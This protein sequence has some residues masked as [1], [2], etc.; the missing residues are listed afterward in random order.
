MIDNVI[1]MFTWARKIAIDK[2]GAFKYKTTFFA[3]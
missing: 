2:T 3:E 1:F